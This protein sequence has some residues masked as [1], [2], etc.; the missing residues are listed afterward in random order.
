MSSQD[1]LKKKLVVLTGPTAVGKTELSIRLAKRTG[2]EIISADSVQVYRGMDIG[3]AKITPEEMQS[4]PHHMI[5]VLDPDE[6]FD[7]AA[8]QR[9]AKQTM[10]GIWKRG[11]LPILVGGTGFYI[12][13]L[14]YDID[15]TANDGD[16][17][18]RRSL[19]EIAGEPGGPSRLH[20]MLEECDPDSAGRIH[21]NNVKRTIRAIEFFRQTGQTMSM[22]NREERARS[23]PYNFVCFVL[24]DDRQIVYDRIDRRVDRMI[25]QGLVDEVRSLRA[26]GVRRGMTSMQALGYKEILDY[27]DGVIPLD[28][29]VARIKRGTR[30]FAKRQI[31]WFKREKEVTWISKADFCRDDD[32]ILTAML[33]ILR[34]HHILE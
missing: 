9:M 12:Q 27:L 23:S 24:T 20:R 26:R 34:E 31:T 11:R 18:L 22:H 4:V 15:F 33:D 25:E 29:A 5:D 6:P 16:L 21:E 8:F 14:V 13:G 10:E 1:L 17:T 28:E 30:H 32:R 7:A 19:E 2:G 3:S